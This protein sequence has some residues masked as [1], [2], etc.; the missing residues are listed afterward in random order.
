MNSADHHLGKLVGVRWLLPTI[1]L[2]AAYCV[3]WI[4]ADYGVMT[5]LVRR[6]LFR[7]ASPDYET[8]LNAVYGL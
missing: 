5:V 4:V 8:T 7:T 6:V 1:A 3:V 2:A